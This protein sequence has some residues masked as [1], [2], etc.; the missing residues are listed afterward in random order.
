MQDN[1]EII[2]LIFKNKNKIYIYMKIVQKVGQFQKQNNDTSVAIT[3]LFIVVVC[4]S[5]TKYR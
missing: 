5:N 1:F 2:L 3:I 4:D